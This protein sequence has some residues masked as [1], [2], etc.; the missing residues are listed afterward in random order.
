MRDMRNQGGGGVKQSS[1]EHRRVGP[2]QTDF[3]VNFTPQFSMSFQTPANLCEA[4]SF[5]HCAVQRAR[6]FKFEK[7]C[8]R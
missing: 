1:F 4:S 5:E 3:S 2:V 8:Q 6:A 7:S